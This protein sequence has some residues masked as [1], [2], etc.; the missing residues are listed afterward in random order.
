MSYEYPLR[1]E[2]RY[3]KE[4]E[5]VAD[6]FEEKLKRVGKNILKATR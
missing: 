6:R 3:R 5:Y 1:G 4:A 2:D